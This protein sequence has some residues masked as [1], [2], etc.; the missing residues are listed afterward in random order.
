[1]WDILTGARKLPG[2]RSIPAG[3]PARHRCCYLGR[4]EDRWNL[5]RPVA[6]TLNCC[7]NSA[8]I[9]IDEALIRRGDLD[10][11]RKTI[12]CDS[13]DRLVVVSFVPDGSGLRLEQE[14]IGGGGRG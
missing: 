6:V 13:C 8:D 12:E 5:R 14:V 9:P 7:S 1:M 10:E 4:Q 2:L 3:L 11:V